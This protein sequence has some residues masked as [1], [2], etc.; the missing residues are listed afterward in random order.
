MSKKSDKRNSETFERRVRE[1]LSA[2]QSAA[3]IAKETGKSYVHTQRIVERIKSEGS[4][5]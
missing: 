3:R 5:P 1:L 4:N 2:G